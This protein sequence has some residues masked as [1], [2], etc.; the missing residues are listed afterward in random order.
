MQYT[1]DI[2]TRGDLSGNKTLSACLISAFR[3]PITG[4]DERLHKEVISPDQEMMS[5]GAPN[6]EI[7]D[8]PHAKQQF[9]TCG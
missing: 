8:E 1:D 7:T 5:A 6:K 9:L 4:R 3:E 2:S